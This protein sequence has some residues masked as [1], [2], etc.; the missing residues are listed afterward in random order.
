MKTNTSKKYFLKR[1]SVINKASH[2]LSNSAKK[3]IVVQ[4][5]LALKK[6]K[7]YKTFRHRKRTKK[8][9]RMLK[10]QKISNRGPLQ[11]RRNNMVLKE[12]SKNK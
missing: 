2:Y 4:C 1:K 6:F 12:K 8:Y 7:K 10:K 9:K 11:R 3:L 5:F